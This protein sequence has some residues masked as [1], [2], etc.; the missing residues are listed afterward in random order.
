[1]KFQELKCFR[2]LSWPKENFSSYCSYIRGGY[3]TYVAN[4]DGSKWLLFSALVLN[5]LV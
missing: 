2:R 4:Y 3:L 5:H 1:M